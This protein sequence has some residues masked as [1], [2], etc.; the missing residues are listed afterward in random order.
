MPTGLTLNLY[1]TAT[2]IH[3]YNR[4]LPVADPPAVNTVVNKHVF[5]FFG[6]DATGNLDS[7][8]NSAL[9]FAARATSCFPGAFPATR[10][11]D[12]AQTEARTAFPAEFCRAY[13][14][15]G[16]PVEQT[17]FI[18]G[19][20]LDNFPFRHAVRAIPGKPASTQVDRRLLFIEPDPS[21]PQAGPDGA[22]PGFRA[23][24][25][26]GLSKLP[27]R[28]PIGD[29]LDELMVYNR[30]VRRVRQMIGAIED[31]VLA[32]VKPLLELGYDDANRRGNTGAIESNPF[33]FQAYL[34]LKLL[35][36]VEGMAASICRILRYSP[37]SAQALFVRNVLILWADGANLL[38]TKG[39][40]SADQRSFLRTFDLGY[41][42]R[43]LTFVIG[44]VSHYYGE[45]DRELLNRL[46]H[47]LYALVAEL[48]SVLDRGEAAPLVES[49]QA[50]FGQEPLASYL[51]QWEATRF[52]QEHQ[53]EINGL[54]TRLAGYI[55]GA[56][57]GFG[58]RAYETLERLTPALPDAI[59]DDL[60]MRYLGFP[61]WDETTYPARS[62]SDVGE[63][64]EVQVVRVSPLDTH[65]LTPLGKDGTPDGRSK[66]RGVSIMHFGA[67]FRR[68]WREN[69]YLWGRLDGAER[70]LW[71]LGDTS[72]E[73]A[74][75]VFRAIVTDEERSL[76]KASSLIRRVKE[77]VAA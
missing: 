49:V 36:V 53:A 15:A 1:V 34:R 48:K 72:D 12:I 42:Q 40:L 25:W 3:G 54:R 33:G 62:L 18:D 27:R 16:S 67:F 50:I 4:P 26:A 68:A 44:R 51:G 66:L 77:Y 57:D 65:R 6:R 35:S 64:D 76:T 56:L 17:F 52:L 13:E 31:E 30:R 11:A 9:A 58:P 60:R 14:L 69:D 38:D 46:K 32:T 63:L 8:H 19:G 10:L 71:L 43:R 55:D 74:K 39:E 29:A 47:D 7:T 61:Y 5:E 23:T 59:R 21:D 22:V 70:L 20:V 24:I 41:G 75:E 37:E 73:S 28:Q 45:A 2:D